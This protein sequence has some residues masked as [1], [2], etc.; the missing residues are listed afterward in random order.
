MMITI[1]EYAD[2]YGLKRSVVYSAVVKGKLKAKDE[3]CG[4][5][6]YLIDENERFELK[7]HIDGYKN[8]TKHPLYS[9]WKSMKERCL[10][11]NSM[12][13]YRY[14]GRGIKICDEWLNSSFSFI[15]W[16]IENGYKRGLQIDRR[17]NDGNYEP[18][19][20]RWVTP[21]E[22]ANN[23]SN[24]VSEQE[25]QRRLNEKV[26]KQIDAQIKKFKNNIEANR[27]GFEFNLSHRGYKRAISNC[28]FELWEIGV[29]DDLIERYMLEAYQEHYGIK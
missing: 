25:L 5:R 22:N 4:T 29:F 26:K 24:N 17:D 18:S 19:N 13:Y 2:K 16:G 14:G 8:I 9:V 21:K 12:S 10:N 23:K 3:Y 20:C 6:R 15:K 27:Q 7:P 11:P 1:Q 28:E